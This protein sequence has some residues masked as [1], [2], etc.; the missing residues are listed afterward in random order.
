[1]F[2]NFADHGA[3]GLVAFPLGVLKVGQLQNAINYMHKN[4]KYK[5]V[6]YLGHARSKCK[7]AH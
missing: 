7:G 2:V 1:V 6:C 4:K 3:P 5:K